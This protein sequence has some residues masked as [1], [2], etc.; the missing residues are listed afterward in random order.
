M[1]RVTL[2]IPGVYHVW[3]ACEESL[4][5]VEI[6]VPLEQRMNLSLSNA[7]IMVYKSPYM[8][9]N[10]TRYRCTASIVQFLKLYYVTAL[11][12][13]ELTWQLLTRANLVGVLQGKS[14]NNYIIC[15]FNP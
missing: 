2:V 7:S 3:Y 1:V 14:Q 4:D 8:N 12:H 15:P 9:R 13:E 6:L 10:I 5:L 11:K